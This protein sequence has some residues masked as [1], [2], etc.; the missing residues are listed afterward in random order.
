VESLAGLPGSAVFIV[1]DALNIPRGGV[2]IKLP[3]TDNVL[4]FWRI[5]DIRFRMLS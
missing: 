5:D 3:Y 2:P 4:Y 1:Q